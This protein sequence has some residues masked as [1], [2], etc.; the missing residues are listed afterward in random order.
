[1]K[2]PR[3]A[4]VTLIELMIVVAIAAILA[5]VTYPGYRQYILRAN[6]TEGQALLLDAAARQER[7][8]AQNSRYVVA[9]GELA[10]LGLPR[11][12]AKGAASPGGWYLLTVEPGTEADG[13][14][15]LT[16]TPQGAQAQDLHCAALSLNTLGEQR[17]T[18]GETA[19]C[20]R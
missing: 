2:G 15:R 6:R 13:G 12:G 4:G 19:D 10:S 5:A 1:M 3:E 7:Y 20:W 14:Y 11:V 16:A 18:A 8:F 17:S 9:T